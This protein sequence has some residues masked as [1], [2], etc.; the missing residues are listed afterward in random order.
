MT[1]KNHVDVSVVVPCFCC[2]K[3]IDR[4]IESVVQQTMR[5]LELILV[6]DV[7]GDDTRAVLEKWHR[8]Y[9]DWIRLVCLDA[10]VGA[11]MAR[12]EGWRLA[13]G[14]YIAFLDSDDSWHPAKLEIQYAYMESHPDIQ[15]SGHGHTIGS[16]PLFSP[17]QVVHARLLSCW[18]VLVKNPFVTPSVMLRRML[19]NRFAEGRRYMEDH[20][21]WLEVVLA[22]GQIALLEMPLATLHKGQVGVAGLSNHIRAMSK[23]DFGNYWVLYKKNLIGAPMLSVCWAWT[24]VKFLRRAIVFGVPRVW[25][26]WRDG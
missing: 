3:T 2:E 15:L 6:D 22:G 12:N 5:P 1:E 7:S 16:S 26:R 24:S 21:L 4:A 19:P 14:K 18:R 11:G 20:L 25:R 8:K 17:S 13:R 10:N 23:A 9:P